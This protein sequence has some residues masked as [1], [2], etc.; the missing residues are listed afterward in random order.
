MELEKPNILYSHERMD[1]LN[2]IVK[3]KY[4]T[5]DKILPEIYKFPIINDETIYL[6]IINK[7][8]FQ[9]KIKLYKK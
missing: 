2:D 8:I 9:V 1:I 7:N 3:N 5:F 6:S 4:N